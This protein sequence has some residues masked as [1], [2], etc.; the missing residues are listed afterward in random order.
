[1][2]EQPPNNSSQGGVSWPLIAA[3]V[4]LVISVAAAGLVIGD[5][6]LTALLAGPPRQADL[7]TA[8]ALPAATANSPAAT[9][10]IA[11]PGPQPDRARITLTPP[12]DDSS[13]FA[14]RLPD[15][16]RAALARSPLAQKTD[17]VEGPPGQPDSDLDVAWETGNRGLLTLTIH[18]RFEPAPI[19]VEGSLTPYSIVGP[20]TVP[21]IVDPAGDASLP[22]GLIAGLLELAIQPGAGTLDQLQ[23]LQALPST[24]S[25]DDQSQN[26]AVILFGI[27][28]AQ[29][30][31]G[32]PTG[33][34]DS[35]SQALR[36]QPDFPAATLN[37]GNV[38][39][40]LGDSTTAQAVYEAFKDI[41][42]YQT[43]VQYN[44]AI[45]TLAG[46]DLDA[47]LKSADALVGANP[48]AAW[49]VN[50]RGTI[51]YRRAEYAPA[52]AD[53]NQAVDLAPATPVLLFNQ[54]Q[55][56]VAAGQT[57]Q[58]L[59]VYDR[60][61]GLA[62]D[63]PV[64]RLK[65]ALAFEAAGKP[66]DA[67]NSLSQ[68]LALD[69]KYVAAY[70]ERA[71]LEVQAGDYVTAL[72]DVDQ[73]LT[74]DPKNGPAYQVSGDALLAQ[75]DWIKAEK[76]YTA[77]AD[78]GVSNAELFAGRGWAHHR[79]REVS[80]AVKDYQQ[81][82][83]LG[84]HDTTVLLRLGFALLDTN[85]KKD[86]LNVLMGAVNGGLDTAEAH[87]GL[88]LALD[89]NFRTDDANTEYQRALALDPNFGD[90]KFLADQPLWTSITIGR[91]MSIVKRL[92]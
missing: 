14:A 89:M 19:S 10:E 65:Q 66:S 5:F 11:T 27:A 44:Q 76:A 73:V 7:S 62:P 35:D 51:H 91:A 47:A 29:A 87:A 67:L 55:A 21:V 85:Q 74:L 75:E 48:S 50:L 57:D 81:A 9:Q 83:S 3:A 33:A 77:A 58:A 46:S 31:L 40:T 60:L 59:A 38:Y 2:S 70:V 54:A 72:A 23:R 8:A 15:A 4:F 39:L 32:D 52:V 43:L 17:V 53:F 22:A 80:N 26:Q 41:S 82:I 28:Q 1:V 16:I 63:N 13:G 42:P 86:A 34:L 18:S 92:K 88:S 24:F 49:S 84:D 79:Q 45:V 64:Y 25:P 69:D 20:E 56:L 68:A 61:L 36:L 37:R 71:R 12:Q 78:N 90:R 30:A 6:D